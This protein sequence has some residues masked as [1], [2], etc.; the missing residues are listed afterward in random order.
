MEFY[1]PKGLDFAI[2]TDQLNHLVVNL[3]LLAPARMRLATT[4][5]RILPFPY[6]QFRL[7]LNKLNG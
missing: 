7:V 5:S 4:P 1:P 6:R 2:A 3:S